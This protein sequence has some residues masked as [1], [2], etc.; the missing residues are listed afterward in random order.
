MNEEEV[1]TAP[2]SGVE[3][4]AELK[5]GF[6]GGGRAWLTGG[7]RRSFAGKRRMH[8]LA[9]ADMSATSFVVACP[10]SPGGSFDQNKTQKRICVLDF[11]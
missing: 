7:C 1:K 6:L 9:S 3:Q 8:V 11:K 5:A 10:D 2:S 4:L